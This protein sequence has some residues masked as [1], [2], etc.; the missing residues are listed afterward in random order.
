[1]YI[2]LIFFYFFKKKLKQDCSGSINKSATNQTTFV[3][4]LL[5]MV[6]KI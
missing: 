4:N 2:V 3:E 1:M 5:Q 6:W